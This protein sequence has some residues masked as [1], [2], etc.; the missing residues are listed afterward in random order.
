MIQ[1]D[2]EGL[3]RQY[4]ANKAKQIL[5]VSEQAICEHSGLKGSHREEI[6]K[7]YLEDIVPE[8]FDIGHGMIYST[9][10]RSHETDIVLWDANNFPRLKMNGHSLYFAESVSAAIEV[11]SQYNAE[12][13]KDIVEK[14][15][16]LKTMIISTCC[17]LEDR[18]LNL[19][20]EV[21]SLFQD[22]QYE[23]CLSS[24]KSIKAGAIIIKGGESFSIE[25]FPKY[26]DLDVQWPDITLFLEAGKVVVK[27]QEESG[28]T[29]RV[30]ESGEDSLLIFTQYLLDALSK[31]VV[32]TEGRF[33]FEDY[34]QNLINKIPY[35]DYDYP[36]TRPSE[37]FK[38]PFFSGI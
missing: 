32:L 12:V 36:C 21:Q 24:P 9:F 25:N 15:Q 19:E 22:T 33:Y 38:K 8:R 2:T 29:I 18:M 3:I 23:G 4:F 6:I 10:T 26:D 35:S 20:C 31:Q 14:T 28:N 27:F 16:D 7:I 13:E 30:Y 17:N 37:G 1:A 5:A 11:K 34:I